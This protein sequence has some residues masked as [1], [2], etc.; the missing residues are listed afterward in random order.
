LTFLAIIAFIL[1]VPVLIGV[2]SW[3]R[4]KFFSGNTDD[5]NKI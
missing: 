4:Y 2:R 5:Q 3:V 1:L